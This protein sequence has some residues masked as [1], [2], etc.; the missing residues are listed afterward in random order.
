MNYDC[1][2][3]NKSKCS[4]IEMAVEGTTLVEHG[5]LQCVG[6]WTIDDELCHLVTYV[7][8]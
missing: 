5:S 2:V 8:R 4:A 1:S 7:I 3:T 6:S